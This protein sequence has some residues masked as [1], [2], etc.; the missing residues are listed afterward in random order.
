MASD[1]YESLR[2]AV[3]QE[4]L[5]AISSTAVGRQTT[6]IFTGSHMADSPVGPLVARDYENEAKCSGVPFVSIILRCEEAEHLRR[7][8]SP[9]RYGGNGA[10]GKLTNV[11][12]LRRIRA[13]EIFKFHCEHELAELDVTELTAPEAARKVKEFVD[14]TL[15]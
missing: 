6:Y 12:T 4:L 5:R 7:A 10:P 9:S 14:S 2:K 3:R 1:E 13:M 15:P 11:E 8:T